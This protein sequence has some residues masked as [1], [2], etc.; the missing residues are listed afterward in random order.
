MFQLRI[1]PIPDILLKFTQ[2]ILFFNFSIL[3]TPAFLALDRSDS[4]CASED[5]EVSQDSPPAL[6]VK[7]EESS[8]PEDIVICWR[9]SGKLWDARM[10]GDGY[11]LSRRLLLFVT[12]E[13]G[14]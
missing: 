8:A 6:P 13:L 14:R 7:P 11:F 3:G 2:F 10:Q 5:E 1:T 4:G 12:P 9:Q